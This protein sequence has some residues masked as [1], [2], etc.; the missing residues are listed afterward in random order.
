MNN[1]KTITSPSD[2]ENAFTTT[3]LKLL[4]IDVQS[5]IRLSKKKSLNYLLV[6]NMLKPREER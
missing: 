6:L 3:F 5:S 2:N 4:T 1:T